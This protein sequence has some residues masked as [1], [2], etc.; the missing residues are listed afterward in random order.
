VTRRLPLS[1]VAGAVGLVCL[2]LVLATGCGG[3]DSPDEAKQDEVKAKLVSRL[4]SL[5]DAQVEV[6]IESSLS[7]GQNNVGVDVA[8][9]ADASAAELDAVGEKVER[10]IWLSRL[11]PLGL[12]N[13]NFTHEGSAERVEQRLYGGT[14]KRQLADK[15]GPRPDGLPAVG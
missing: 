6:T 11:D 12:I 10:T 1:T 14:D 8:L 15:Y 5:P 3:N 4:E 9:P 7:G 2:V 13:I